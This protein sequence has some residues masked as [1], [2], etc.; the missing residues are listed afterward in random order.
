MR[1]SV[2]IVED[3]E[4]ILTLYAN[5]MK[6]EG[7]HV[8][9]ATDGEQG[10]AI[11]T[12]EKPDVILLDILL[13]LMDGVDVLRKLRAEGVRSKVVILTASP[14]LHVNEGVRLGIYAYLNKAISTPKEVI[15]VVKDAVKAKD[16]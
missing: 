5:V 14:I 1:K 4:D 6:K 11:A 15:A 12:K 7:F 8:L 3:E 16:D 2:L 10:F 13:P 9:T